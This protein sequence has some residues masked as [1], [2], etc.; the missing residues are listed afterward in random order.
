[1]SENDTRMPKLV[2][3]IY[4]PGGKDENILERENVF[5]EIYLSNCNGITLLHIKYILKDTGQV[6]HEATV[7]GYFAIETTLKI[8]IK[9]CDQKDNDKK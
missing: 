5:P 9:E 3:E 8:N 4:L 7:A 1:M 6:I 2:G